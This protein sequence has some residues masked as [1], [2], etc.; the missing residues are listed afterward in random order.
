MAFNPELLRPGDVLLYR[1]EGAFSQFIRLKTWSNYSHVEVY[2]GGGYSLASR[3]GQW[4]DRFPTRYAD[5]A[6]VLRLCPTLPGSGKP[7]DPKS[8]TPGM[9]GLP[10][11]FDIEAGREWFRSVARGQR[12]D[13]WGL[14]SFANA[15]WQGRENGALFCSEFAARFFRMSIAGGLGLVDDG[16]IRLQLKALGLDPW[17][18]K[19]ADAIPPQGFDDSPFF[20]DVSS[21]LEVGNGKG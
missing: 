11:P 20:I 18:G 14:A 15:K 1:G 10:T 6:T 8:G 4:C 21:N 9:P 5:L 3:N 2:D 16:N 7:A 12:Y 17:R 13:W 19:N